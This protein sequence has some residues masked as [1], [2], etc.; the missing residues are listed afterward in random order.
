MPEPACQFR[1]GRVRR[2]RRQAARSIE[3]RASRTLCTKPV[4]ASEEGPM[5]SPEEVVREFCAVV[6]KRDTELLR[7]LLADGIVYHNI[8]MAP[9][10]GVDA[11][12]A[13][14]EGQWQMF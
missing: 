8:G 7:P 6:S 13:N 1:S 5:R 11:V 3:R 4:V 14:L 2:A 9:T 10:T 12:L